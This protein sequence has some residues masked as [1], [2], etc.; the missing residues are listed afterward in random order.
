MRQLLSRTGAAACALAVCAAF[1]AANA[2]SPQTVPGVS[3]IVPVEQ[4]GEA[5]RPDSGN[6]DFWYNNTLDGDVN[7]GQSAAPQPHVEGGGNVEQ[8]ELQRMFPETDWPK[9]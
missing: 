8:Q 1:S 2:G 7:D 4:T 5:E 6:R 9:K 3:Y